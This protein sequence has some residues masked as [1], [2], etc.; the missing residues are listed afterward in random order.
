MT[1]SSNTGSSNT[2]L[3]ILE[4]CAFISIF[5][6]KSQ[7]SARLRGPLG[8]QHI[9]LLFGPILVEGQGRGAASM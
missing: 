7:R 8:I 5:T 4:K 3:E 6:L 9:Q 2:A 1:R